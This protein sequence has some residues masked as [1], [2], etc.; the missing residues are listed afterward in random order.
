M[1]GSA[2]GYWS[3]PAAETHAG[4]RVRIVTDSASDILPTHAR[5]LGIILVPNRVILDGEVLRD[6]IDIT[7]SQFY[8]A[9]ANAKSLPHTRPAPVEDLHAAYQF[10]FRQGATEVV[11]LHVSGRLSQ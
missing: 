3:P 2:G 6:G 7:A 10:A 4:S 11:A 1:G 9:L 5:V 8:A